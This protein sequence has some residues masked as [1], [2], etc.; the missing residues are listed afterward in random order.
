MNPAL[1]RLRPVALAVTALVAASGLSTDST[2]ASSAGYVDDSGQA[3]AN[4][5]GVSITQESARYIV[6]FAEQPL[7]LYNS[8]AAS[9]P[10]NGI[11][12]IP[13]KTMSNGRSRL[14]VHSTQ[15]KNY[16]SYVKQ[17]QTQHLSD[18]ATA[19]GHA[20]KVS[21]TMQ[22]A[23]NAAVMV[24]SPQE[25][26][27]VA[28]VQGVVAVERDYP[29]P[30]ATDIGPGFIGAASVWWGTPAGQDSIFASGFDNS[31][32]FRG[33]GVVI[34]DIDT[35]YNS[36][37]PSFQP[38][39]INGYTVQNPLGTGNFIGQCSLGAG[40]SGISLAGCNDK[41]IGAYDEIDLTESDPNFSGTYSVEDTQGHG[42][43][44]AS[45][46]GG[47][48]R[49]GTLTGYTAL[50]SGVA[51]H[52][53]LVI[54]YACSPDTNIQ[55]SS[56]ATS[57]SV[58]QAIQDG[59]VDALNYSISGGTDPWH[60]STSLA[61]LS[62]TDAGIFVAAAAGNTGTSVPNQIPG[63]ANHA[64]PWVT[65]AAA[66]THT[67]G[68]IAPDLTV[69]GPGTPPANIQ[70]QPLTEAAGDV[71]PTAT[72]T[73]NIVLSPQFHINDTGGSDGCGLPAGVSTSPSYP[74]NVFQGSIALV[75]RGTCG[76]YVKAKNAEAAGAV[77]TIISDNRPEAPLLPS[78]APVPPTAPPVVTPVYGITQALGGNLQTFLAAQTASTGTAVIPFP[79]IRQPTVPDVLANFS[80][81]GPVTSGVIKPD[82]SA[83]GVNIL[84]AFNNLN[85]DGS[86][87]GADF[88]GLD[89]GTSMATPH[90]TGSGALLLGLHPDWS[91]AEAK[92]ALMM[93][94][95]EVGMFKANGTTPADFFDIGSGRLQDYLASRAGLVLN[96]TGL[97]FFSADPG[98][99]GD[100]STLNIASMQSSTCINGCSFVRKFRSTQA[101]GVTWTA[102]VDPSSDPGL[103]ISVTP[104]SF[105]ATAN[106]N[107]APIEFDVDSHTLTSDGT[108][109]FAEVVLTPSDAT[110]TPL[111]LTFAI[112]VPA[113]TIAA[114][115]NPVNIAVG[116]AANASQ[117]LD[118]LNIGGPSLNVSQTTTGSAPYVWNNQASADNF[119][120]PSVQYTGKSASDTDAFASDDFTITGNAPVD[121]SKIVTPGFEL[122]GHTLASFGASLPVHWR[123]YSDAGGKP[124]SDPDTNGP[125][126]FSYDATAGSAGVS[127]VGKFGGDISLNLIAA[128][129][130]TALPAGHY[131]LVVYPTLPCND[132]AGGCS[133]NWFWLTGNFGSG[134]A[135]VAIEPQ[136]GQPWTPTDPSAGA[137][138][139]MH[140]EAAASCASPSWLSQTGLPTT[141]GGLDFAAVNVTAT[142]PLGA[143]AATA[144]LCLASNDAVT[145]ILPVQIN[146]TATVVPNAPTVTKG[147]SP[148]SVTTGV[149]S[150]ATITLSNSNA[151][152]ATLSANL[153]DTLPTNLVATGGTGA[154]TC[155][156][157][158]GVTISG[159]GD[160][161]TLGSGAQIPG[162]GSCTVTFTTTSSVAATYTNTIA[163][164]A[165][166]TNDGNNAAAGSATLT[167]TPVVAPTATAAFS[168]TSV[169]TS[170][171]ST[172]TITL[173]NTNAGPATLTSPFSN[174]L[175]TGVLV[176]A[177]PNAATTCTPGTVTGNAGDSSFSL[178]S[179]A[180]IPASG[181]CTVQVDVSASTAAVYTDTIAP[182][183]LVT[184]IG[185]NSGSSSSNVVVTGTFPAPYCTK[186][187]PAGAVFAITLVNFA[188]INNTSPTPSTVALENFTGVA[189]GTVGPGGFYVITLGGFTAGANQFFNRVYFD[190]NHDGVFNEDGSERYEAGSIISSTGTDGV[191]SSGG[192]LVPQTAV[193]GLTRMR[194]VKDF[195]SANSVSACDSTSPGVDGQA[196]DYLVNVDPNA[197]LP[198]APPFVAKA[199]SPNYV[200]AG[201]GAISTLTITLTNVNATALATTAALTDTFP[202][203]LVV[204]PTPNAST[205]CGGSP[206]FTP[207]AG[208][209]SLVLGSGASIPGN[210]TCT[211]QV[212]VTTGTGGIYV[213]TIAQGAV[214]SANGNSPSAASATVQFNGGAPTYSTGFES[215]FTVNNINGQQGWFAST[216]TYWKV[217][218]TNPK[219]GTQELRATATT[220]SSGQTFALSPIV[221]VGTSAF[222][223][224]SAD[225]AITAVSTGETFDFEPQDNDAGLILTDVEFL[226]GAGN[227]IL[228]LD[229]SDQLLHDTGATWAGSGTYQHVEVGVN[230]ANASMAVCLNGTQIFT[231]T[232]FAVNPSNVAVLAARGTGTQN[233][234]LDVD[235]LV[236]DNLSTVTCVPPAAPTAPSGQAVAGHVA[237][238]V[239]NSAAQAQ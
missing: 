166:Q 101:T 110:L 42:S 66:T 71:P 63:T 164:G 143:A 126:V 88:I 83:P 163:A 2:Y 161:V 154:T 212:D 140:L 144:Y 95:K 46:A 68:A 89:S 175:P 11:S 60:D 203:G 23:L 176:A 238:G 25:A 84:A 111:H 129:Q 228:V 120:F 200:S 28:K 192:V 230:R 168:P 201:A 64:E 147:F 183:S 202:T 40:D 10:V 209:T 155:S 105:P 78:V 13:F 81:L 178:S 104:S 87:N 35:G 189:P 27:K 198:P 62:A 1:F 26:A 211:V 191:S 91:P 190:W 19:L 225:I 121:L 45:T 232:A 74:A 32:G 215:P 235:N 116:S 137:G 150:T 30:L 217:V 128:G 76:F 4:L 214:Q 94:G 227:H 106:H 181:S 170:A 173:A 125:A 174:T 43:H 207:V 108:F 224:A 97:N 156:G 52:A 193:P 159:A 77:A 157:G 39:D 167:V 221:P 109:H 72:I 153:V 133:E 9:K 73:G 75:S 127:V 48:Q 54:Y 136:A 58:D 59:I 222:S 165:L 61:F 79:A 132:N 53:N 142:P 172:L 239:L 185:T 93:T 21:V 219:T 226:K 115:P 34:G 186:T 18:I 204:A 114:D 216:A 6:R 123:I 122:S 152:A 218:A 49:S 206:T 16:V 90:T 160:S 56:A 31:G 220:A 29:H 117:E 169:A 162:A 82:I 205:T 55:C 184:D 231:G 41:V 195:G 99:S 119:G 229:G 86:T 103:A 96:E 194:V 131:W 24:M 177:T 234:L 51:P 134:S 5:V 199:F 208:D 138:F 107:T 8:V 12:Q 33:D 179:G 223:T 98:A 20:P 3:R 197:V 113:P 44:T 15:A 151:T 149:N 187:Y 171:P 237:T 102:S 38:A 180:H 36:M 100:P 141:I 57:A 50:L 130:H 135:P 80:L 7:A 67:G 145:P 139:A 70:E 196:E 158:A 236:L 37:S 65:T 148:S 146:A 85:A 118:V 112:A 210:G 17:Q 22:H 233:N 182:G 188:G 69:T 213:N 14:D 92:S 47:D 124:S